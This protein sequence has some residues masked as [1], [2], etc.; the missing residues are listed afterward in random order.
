MPAL[1]TNVTS[2]TTGSGQSHS[3][4]CTVFV[5]GT[6]DGATV[7]IEGSPT[8]NTADYVKLDR[9]IV[10]QA[11]FIDRTGASAVDGQGTYYLRAVLTN[12]G[13]STSVSVETTQ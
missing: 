9:S 11:Q 4:P 5:T 1:L 3:G 13:S 7:V 10:P 6:M 12:A 2:D 8:T